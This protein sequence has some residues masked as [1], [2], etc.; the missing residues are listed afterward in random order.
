MRFDPLV[1]NTH[2][3]PRAA[4]PEGQNPFDARCA[5][6][7]QRIC[8]TCKHYTGPLRAEPR[9]ARCEKFGTIKS[10]RARAWECQEWGRK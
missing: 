6:H 2:A 8:G 5:L 10:A 4:R 7:L 9:A 1:S 3:R